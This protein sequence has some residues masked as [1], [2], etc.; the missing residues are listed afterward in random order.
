M[1][2]IGDHLDPLH[3]NQPISR[4]VA[5][6]ILEQLDLCG[7]KRIYGVIGDAIFGLMDAIAKQNR[8]VF[9]SVKHE[10]VAAM[11]ASAEAKCTGGLGVCIAQMGPGLANLINGLG[12]AH[13]DGSPVLAI[14][15]QAP[16]KKIGTTYKQYINQQELVQAISDYSELVVHPDAVIDSLTKAI[17]TSIGNG[18]VS[19]LSIPVDIFTAQTL[20]QPNRV[21]IVSEKGGCTNKLEQVLQF[22]RLAKN[23]IILVG[24]EVRHFRL[25]IQQLAEHWG[26]GVTLGYG[27]TGIFP[28]SFQLGLGGLGEGGNPFLT[29]LFKQADVILA[30]GTSWWPKGHTPTNARVIQ[31][32]DRRIK[33]GN[34]MPLDCSMVGNIEEIVLQ[35]INGLQ[36]HNHNQN[37]INQISQCKQN[38]SNQNESEG[39]RSGYPLHPSKIVR[40]IER[41]TSENTIIALDE[42]D[43]TLWFMR[44]FRAQCEHVLLSSRWRTMGFGLPAA[45]AA[46]LCM[47]TK[48]VVC[49]TG[50]GGLGMVLADLLTATRYQ[51]QITLIVFNNGTLQ[52]EKNK[53]ELK[54]LIPEGTEI[55]NPDFI[56][57]ASACGWDAYRIQTEDELEQLLKVVQTSKNPVLIDV[58]TS[59]IK[60]PNYQGI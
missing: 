5:E 15:G 43:S 57:L 59:Q 51:L 54:G 24:K 48:N 58:P 4:T 60:Y 29:E 53:M 13:L 35:L 10:S 17:H 14:T 11:M 25:D 6:A 49:I 19:H 30:V 7:V 36:T 21:P 16:V 38:W 9:I 22:M 3:K 41:W 2:E 26:S 55:A 42:G 50:D 56:K 32:Q 45:M 34:G 44:N 8:I 28:E 18:A 37:W 1:S 47:P 20:V 23:P 31:I 52:M 33:L 27:A 39:K 40:M 12:D 46:K